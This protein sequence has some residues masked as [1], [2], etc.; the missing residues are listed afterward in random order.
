MSSLT[1]KDSGVDITKGN[2]LIER[3]KPIGTI[4][5]EASTVNVAFVDE[6]GYSKSSFSFSNG[7]LSNS[8][9]SR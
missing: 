9:K 7:F 4:S 8:V 2:Q 6:Y 3:I 5:T 1:Y